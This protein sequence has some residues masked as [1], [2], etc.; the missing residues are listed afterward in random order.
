MGRKP[1]Y[2]SRQPLPEKTVTGFGTV[3]LIAAALIVIML[4]TTMG[5]GLDQNNLTPQNLDEG[6]SLQGV[7]N[8]GSQGQDS[9]YD[10]RQSIRCSF[11]GGE[12]PPGAGDS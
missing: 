5:T 8:T 7:P 10:L 2:S 3:F 4:A 11:G 1:L 9:M 6:D 12:C